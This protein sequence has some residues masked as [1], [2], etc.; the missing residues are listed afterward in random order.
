MHEISLNK[1]ISI[2]VL[3]LYSRTY[4]EEGQIT[5]AIEFLNRYLIIGNK[6][7]NYL[8]HLGAFYVMI[9]QN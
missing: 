1:N 8:A 3:I 2:E 9:N 6:S 7:G 5:K 4:R